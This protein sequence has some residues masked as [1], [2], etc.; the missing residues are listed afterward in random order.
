MNSLLLSVSLLLAQPELR[1]TGK[2]VDYHGSARLCTVESY[3]DAKFYCATPVELADADVAKRVRIVM[4]R[5]VPSGAMATAMHDMTRSNFAAPQFKDELARMAA[6]IRSAKWV[7]G[8]EF[9]FVHV[10]G[11]GLVLES[12]DRVLRIDSVAFSKAFWHNYFGHNNCGE[13]LK[14]ALSANIKKEKS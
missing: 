14:E 9:V 3:V 1:L 13:T 5:W 12:G 8:T 11:K 2:G 6:F 7:R 10:P 4:L